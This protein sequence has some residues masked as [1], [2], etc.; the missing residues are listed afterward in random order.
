MQ[1]VCIYVL[2]HVSERTKILNKSIIIR[3]KAENKNYFDSS[4][5]VIV[6][7]SRMDEGA[8]AT[9]LVREV[10]EQKD[11]YECQLE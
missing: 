2:S 9:T 1:R 8:H 4:Q 7:R 6:L 10:R 3:E 5:I 11:T